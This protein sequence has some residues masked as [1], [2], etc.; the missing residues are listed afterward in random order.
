M[1]ASLRRPAA[2]AQ[3]LV[4][5]PLPDEDLFAYLQRT[6]GGFDRTRYLQLLGEANAYKE[7]DDAIGV[8]A[9]DDAARTHARS[10]LAATRLTDIDAHPVIEDDL[11]AL[12]R[13]TVDVAAQQLSA[14]W[15]VGQLRDLLLTQDGASI[16][17]V[18]R[19]L[20]SDVIGCVVKLMTDDELRAVS[21][22]VHVPLPGSQIGA[23]G[24]LGARVQPNSPT[25]HPDDIRWQV[26]DA[27][28]YGV[29]DVLLGTNPVSS[30]P[31]Q[32][33]RTEHTLQEVL[34]VFELTDVLPHCV[35][36]HI[37]VQALVEAQHPGRTALWFQSLAGSDAANR[38][39]GVTVEG[40]LAHAE[41]RTGRYGLYL[42]TGQG[43]DFTNGHAQGADM[44]LH[45]SRKYGLVRALA[46][47]VATAQ[48]RHGQR[49][50][51]WVHVNDVAGFIGPEVFRRR[52]QLVRCCLE[53]LLMGKLHGLTIGLDVCAT[54]HMDIGPD[55]LDWCLEQVMPASPAYLM[56]LPTK[57]DPMLG[58][59]TTGYQD[60]VRLRAQ[61]GRRINPPMQ[62]FFESL[63]VLDAT[64][65]PGPHF[66]D[67]LHV[68]EAYS[69]RRGDLRPAEA[70]RAE[71][72]EA[73]AAVRARGVFLVTGHGAQPHDL[74]PTLAR[75]I[76]TLCTESRRA[77]H[78]SMSPAF[79]AS[80]PHAVAVQSCSPDRNT[81]ILHPTSGEVL[82]PAAVA[83]LHA[84]AAQ[85][86]GT[87][88]AQIV[89]SDGLNALAIQ[90]PG[91]LLPFLEALRATL[92]TQGWRVAPEHV[93]ITSGRVRAGYLTGEQL[94]AGQ[95]G[96]RMLLH[97]VGERPGTGHHTFSVYFTNADGTR[98]STPGAVDHD[99]TRVVSGISHTTLA[100]LDAVALVCRFVGPRGGSA[101]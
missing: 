35:L 79:V 88:D 48:M 9:P 75:A 67:P 4:L 93:V 37:D 78:A 63:G 77:F 44:V 50:A 45:E 19:G 76:D 71:G 94:F 72:T 62:A 29:G 34:S 57:V 41:S 22:K 20:S 25:D 84:L 28:A 56:A 1:P 81:F 89:V 65:A 98:W 53:D 96:P 15:S 40:M 12:L 39:F 54:L 66:G 14:S 18:A 80:I 49:P 43:A 99:I 24:F 27:W 52:E 73:I 7:G 30:E 13:A 86:D 11:G 5:P 36:A 16:A 21:G 95:R 83:T 91:H 59:L 61:F 23:E 97:I 33:A 74:E 10:M 42:E 92:T 87:I 32:V 2:P 64:G 70:L 68:Y 31:A 69:R 8:A 51:P 46:A 101:S 26:F 90:Q 58:Y 17:A 82:S 47:R 38:T 6:T 3:M 100:P 55:D 60:H 85:R